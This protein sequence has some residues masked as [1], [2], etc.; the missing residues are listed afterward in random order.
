MRRA[1]G[2]EASEGP[3]DVSTPLILC[4]HA[5]SESWFAALSVRPADLERHLRILH[6]RGYTA[7]TFTA[8]VHD[9]RPARTVA[10]TFDDAFRS[11]FELAFPILSRLGIPATVFAPTAFV[12]RDSPMRWP[13]ID[14]WLGGRHEEELLPMSW[15]QLRALAD[16]GWEIGS[17]TRTHTRLTELSDAALDRELMG[18]RLEC[19]ENLGLP[20]RSLAYPF[21]EHDR[22]TVEAAA[23]AGYE[24]A[25]SLPARWNEPEPL[26]WP[27][28]GVYHR[29]RDLRFRLKV[30]PLVRRLRG[31]RAFG[32]LS[33]LRGRA[34]SE[35]RSESS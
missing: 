29:D 14:H 5:L 2:G 16:A 10:V 26:S 13:E 22:R 32:F 23:T 28:V 9:R 15:R 33:E 21:G 8:A 17:H 4:Y 18:S 7:T 3:R 35:R 27:R 12:G 20:C 34:A 6:G 25:C 31:G 19:A 1:S 24:A 30:S 11:V